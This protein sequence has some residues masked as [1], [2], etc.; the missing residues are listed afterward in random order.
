MAKQT[1]TPAKQPSSRL[2]SVLAYMAAGLIGTS[3]LTMFAAL[4]IAATGSATPEVGQQ[5]LP[6]I[7]VFYPQ[8]GLIAGAASI[9]ALLVVSIRRRSRENRAN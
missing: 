4:I 3:V 2:E 1:K 5:V 9:I 7:L 6:P 8:F